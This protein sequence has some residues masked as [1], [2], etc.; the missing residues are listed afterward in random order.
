M[1]LTQSEYIAYLQFHCGVVHADFCYNSSCGGVC[2]ISAEFTAVDGRPVD[3]VVSYPLESAEL[4]VSQTAR[5]GRPFQLGAREA[6][7]LAATLNRWMPPRDPA[8][9]ELRP[10]PVG[11]GVR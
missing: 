10:Q 6:R 3:V 5:D 8:P 2:T 4:V 7:R 9:R 11:A 1:N